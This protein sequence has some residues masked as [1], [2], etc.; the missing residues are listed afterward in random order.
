VVFIRGSTGRLIDDENVLGGVM[1][2]M[3]ELTRQ[4][5]VVPVLPQTNQ[6]ALSID[7]LFGRLQNVVAVARK[8]H[9]EL[10]GYHLYDVLLRMEAGELRAVLDFRR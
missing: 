7:A 1:N 8:S 9:P 10:T 5:V 3:T 6:D 2:L 4:H